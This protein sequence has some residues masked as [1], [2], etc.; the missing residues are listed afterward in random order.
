MN[1][2]E[3]AGTSVTTPSAHFVR[4]AAR[5]RNEFNRAAALLVGIATGLL[6]DHKL[7]DEKIHFLDDWLRANDAIACCWPGN[8]VRDRIRAVLADGV[9]TET[10][11]K[12]LL[13]TLQALIG[14]ALD[15]LAAS[16]HVTS[17]AFDEVKAIKIGGSV[18]CL[19]GNFVYAPREV[20]GA[21]IEHRG[22]I[23]LG[24]VTQ[25]LTYLVVGGLGSEEWKFGSFGTK[26]EKAVS[27]RA[28]GIPVQIVHED[29]WAASL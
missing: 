26:I 15:D 28:R 27:Y 3:T 8:V 22:G 9:I 20:C 6:G 1:P 19:T 2:G 10:E 12:H 14:G 13:D 16:T 18:F 25:S 5:Y 24:H 11:R 21:E 17:L 23:V 7:S 29:V 4:Q